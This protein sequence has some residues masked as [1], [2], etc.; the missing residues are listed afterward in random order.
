M[1]Q[2]DMVHL[3]LR[4]AN[5]FLTCSASYQ[6]Q[7]MELYDP[8][9]IALPLPPVFTS[10]STTTTAA[11]TTTEPMS[12][13]SSIQ[14]ALPLGYTG[15]SSSNNNNNDNGSNNG[16]TVAAPTFEHTSTASVRRAVEHLLV[17]RKYVMKLG[18]FGHCCM[19]QDRHLIQEGETRYCARELINLEDLKELDPAAADM[20]SLGAS[21]YELCLGRPLGSDGEAGMHEW[22]NLRDGRLD[23]DLCSRYSPQ[24]VSVLTQLLHPDPMKRPQAVDLVEEI[25][26]QTY[27]G[28]CFDAIFNTADG[29]KRSNTSDN[30]SNS[31]NNSQDELRQVLRENADLRQQ[32]QQSKQHV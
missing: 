4:P 20:F 26:P 18:D 9:R 28:F 3:D 23:D 22:H 6:T 11:A 31:S 29:H 1:H 32:L 17:Q 15:N 12:I 13:F 25:L 30:A 2:R 5:I 14:N 27:V 19:R 10:S 21:V 16:T 7:P 8:Q 24:L